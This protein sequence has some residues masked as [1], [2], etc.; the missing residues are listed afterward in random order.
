MRLSDPA[1]VITDE[2]FEDPVGRSG[3]IIIEST[4]GEPK[5]SILRPLTSTV[6]IRLDT[7]S[8]ATSL[9]MNGSGVEQRVVREDSISNHDVD[10]NLL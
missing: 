3:V 6:G 8:R 9:D 1:T 2:L 4:G 7:R 10:H 5:R